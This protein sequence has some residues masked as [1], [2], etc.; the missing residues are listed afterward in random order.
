MSLMA[1]IDVAELTVCLDL[2]HPLAYLAP[3]GARP[4]LCTANFAGSPPRYPARIVGMGLLSPS[5]VVNRYRVSDIGGEHSLCNPLRR[6]RAACEA[7][8][9]G[10]S[11]APSHPE[12][13]SMSQEQSTPHGPF[14]FSNARIGR[15]KLLVGAAALAAASA[16]GAGSAAA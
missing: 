9:T 15:R 13:E 6:E 14:D 10:G 12:G 1:D 3:S 4:T 16:S 2:R 5:P 8:S 7:F 11:R